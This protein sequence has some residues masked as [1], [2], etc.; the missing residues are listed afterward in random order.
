MIYN[1]LLCVGDSLTYGARDQFGRNY[2]LELGRLMTEHTGEEWYCITEAVNGRI[3]SEVAR[4]AYGIIA[5]YPD[6]YGVLLLI[7]TNDS[8]RAIPPEIYAYNVRQIVRVCRVLGKKV[9]V[10]SVPTIAVERHFLWYDQACLTRL[11]EYNQILKDM[12]HVRFVDIRDV[13]GDAELIDGVHF[14]HEANVKL[15]EYLVGCLF[16]SK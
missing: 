2:P 12:D 13:I 10:L 11:E 7:G 3:S 4:D 9:H 1:L 8:R 15:A 5:K 6:A 16:G 14:T